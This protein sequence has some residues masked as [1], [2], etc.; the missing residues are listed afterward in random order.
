[1]SDRISIAEATEGF[2]IAALVRSL[3][4]LGVLD[5]MASPAEPAD[6]AA[7]AQ[8]DPRL[9]RLTLE[10]LAGRTHLVRREGERYLTTSEWNDYARAHVRQYVGA[11]GRLVL[12]SAAV[13]G[14]PDTGPGL[15]DHDQHARSY[16]G[17]PTASGVVAD[18]VRQLDLSPTLDLGCGTG[19]MLVELGLNDRNFVGWGLE[20]SK[21][22]CDEA[23]A[24]IVAHG[25]HDRIT[26]VQGD[27][28][29]SGPL[30]SLRHTG[31]RSITALSLLNELWGGSDGQAAVTAWLRRL[32]E[33]FP[34]R[35]LVVCDYFGRLG[36]VAPPWRSWTALH[37]LVQTYSGQGVPPPDHDAWRDAY[38]QAGASLLHMIEDQELSFFVHLVK[39]PGQAGSGA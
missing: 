28:F 19:A 29:D 10:Y 38:D 8:V 9:L 31:F 25:L 20:K 6:L 35:A 39:L 33:T 15:V 23:R 32:A 16:S 37:D 11:Y 7:A 2:H 26:V 21:A 12:N 22:M 3:D 5:A 18:L 1:M 17:A 14:D 30:T 34:G 4:E 24:R 13:L 36:H 27:A